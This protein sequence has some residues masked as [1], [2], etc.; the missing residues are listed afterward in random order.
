MNKPVCDRME[1]KNCGGMPLLT[2]LALMMRVNPIALIF[3]LREFVIDARVSRRAGE[4][5]QTLGPVR[6]PCIG[7][8]FFRAELGETTGTEK[9]GERG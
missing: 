5:V 3:A 8:G 9:T 4:G 6:K 2:G 1:R 7:S